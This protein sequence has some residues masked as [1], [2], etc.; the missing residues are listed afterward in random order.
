[1][2]NLNI[3]LRIRHE[4]SLRLNAEKSKADGL[5]IFFDIQMRRLRWKLMSFEKILLKI[6]KFKT[7]H[8]FEC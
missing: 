4:K 7:D 1:M 6:F 2:K 5:N 3:K 8:V